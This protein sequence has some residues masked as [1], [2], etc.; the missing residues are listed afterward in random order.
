MKIEISNKVAA[1]FPTYSRGLL[2]VENLKNQAVP[3]RLAD[4]V[5]DAHASLRAAPID[6]EADERCRVWAEAFR[7]C[8]V[9]PKRFPPAHVAL[10][11]RVQKGGQVP[12]VSPAVAVMTLI[13]LKHV[14][15]VGGDDVR[16]MRGA[17]TLG[18]AAGDEMFAPLGKPEAS[19]CVD[20]G[21]IVYTTGGGEIAC[22]RW[23]W[24]NSDS[25]AIRAPTTDLL[26]NFDALGCGSVSR[27]LEAREEAA[28]WF[29]R[30]GADLSASLLCC[31]SGVTKAELPLM[32]GAG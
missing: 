28:V 14:M 7:R 16:C 18:Y 26:M 24:R 30:M 5:R 2:L 27:C 20:G 22:R 8:G 25:T 4:A 32:S 31:H 11:K 23:C 13:A 6:V 15:P 3:D 29:G 17:G 19:E 1:D 10:L 12:L 9:N 21:E